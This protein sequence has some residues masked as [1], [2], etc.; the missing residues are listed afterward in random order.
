MSSQELDGSRLELEVTESSII[1]NTERAAAAIRK[2][3]DMKV[4]ISLDDFG[5][6]FSSIGH[7]RAL[8]FDRVKLDRSLIKEVL[9]S[10]QALLLLRATITMA[11]ALGLPTTAEGIEREEEIPLL[12]LAGC[13]QF[14][15][16]LFSKPV[17]AAAITEVLLGRQELKVA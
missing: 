9:T 10:P 11:E 5:S 4:R 16:Y 3:H 13:H 1:E 15:G 7:L 2:L 12:R 6:G 8:R 17:P 14:Q